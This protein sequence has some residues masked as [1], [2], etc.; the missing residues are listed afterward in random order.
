MT[1][2]IYGAVRVTDERLETKRIIQRYWEELM[3]L[4]HL[5]P[6]LESPALLYLD[7]S[8]AE[9]WSAPVWLRFAIGSTPGE[10]KADKL[11]GEAIETGY[12]IL[13]EKQ[14]DLTIETVWTRVPQWRAMAM[15]FLHE[16]IMDAYLAV[17]H[18][19]GDAV[20]IE[21]A[22]RLPLMTVLQEVWLNYAVD[23]GNEDAVLYHIDLSKFPP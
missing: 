23:Q 4:H 22:Q 13:N 8:I 6:Q 19:S 10:D 2:L 17:E 12:R 18:A 3:P 5:W 7:S 1:M 20:G 14:P 21:D 11:L 9:L 15:L 16:E